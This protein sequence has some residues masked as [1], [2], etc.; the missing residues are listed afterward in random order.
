MTKDAL[1]NQMRKIKKEALAMKE[2]AVGRDVPA[3]PAK[4]RGRA[5]KSVSPVKKDG[6]YNYIPSD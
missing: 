4:G 1:E 3:A 2:D 5:K 6:M